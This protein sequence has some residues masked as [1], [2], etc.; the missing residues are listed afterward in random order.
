MQVRW[1]SPAAQDLEEI[2][3][4][5]Q[6]DSESVA[7][8]VAKTLFDDA[9]SL[10]LMHSRG[11]VGRSPGTRELVIPGLPYIIVY[12]VKSTVIQILHIYHGAR[13][14]QGEK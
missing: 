4:Y 3:R 9:N 6:R 8:A 7:R 14:W 10:D 13:D 5:I 2:T 11:R 12:Q 1:T